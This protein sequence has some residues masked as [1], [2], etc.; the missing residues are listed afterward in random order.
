MKRSDA[1]KLLVNLLLT[2]ILLFQVSQAYACDTR[3]WP[4]YPRKGEYVQGSYELIP[5]VMVYSPKA[6]IKQRPDVFLAEL[7]L[8]KELSDAAAV[9]EAT[10]GDQLDKVQ[11]VFYRLCERMG[12][13]NIE[14]VIQEGLNIYLM[15]EMSFARERAK[16]VGGVTA[17]GFSFYANREIWIDVSNPGWQNVL[18]HELGHFYD[19]Y[20]YEQNGEL[21]SFKLYPDGYWSAS[22][23]NYFG[24]LPWVEAP[25]EWFAEAFTYC[26][27]YPDLPSY[28]PLDLYEKHHPGVKAE[29][30]R[31]AEYL[32]NM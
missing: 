20:H 9:I 7:P 1:N 15:P 3:P 29:I 31:G 4:D 26:Y 6:S 11:D 2:F 23:L 32:R 30:L 10:Y 24:A 16:K 8:T 28:P 27:G 17:N 21:L 5:G 18:I 12:K 22:I 19:N 13:E 14:A 25:S